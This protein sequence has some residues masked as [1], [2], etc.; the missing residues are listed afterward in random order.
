MLTCVPCGASESLTERYIG[1][2]SGPKVSV[3]SMGLCSLGSTL[4]D[5]RISPSLAV[6]WAK[7]RAAAQRPIMT[8]AAIF[9]MFFTSCGL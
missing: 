8:V 3:A 7:T 9:L 1:L 6:L 5:V 4:R 2:A